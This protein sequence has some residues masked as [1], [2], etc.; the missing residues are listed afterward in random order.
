M[1]ICLDYTHGHASTHK[2]IIRIIRLIF[3]FCEDKKR[4]KNNT[5]TH[6]WQYDIHHATHMI[7]TPDCVYTWASSTHLYTA[8]MIFH[9][10]R[11]HGTSWQSIYK[12]ALWFGYATSFL[13]LFFLPSR[14]H[15]HN[16]CVQVMVL[17][18]INKTYMTHVCLCLG[19]CV[20]MCVSVHVWSVCVF[21]VWVW[22]SSLWPR[23]RKFTTNAL[24]VVTI[25]A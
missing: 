19:V 21:F 24:R 22:S 23:H 4:K 3:I 6:P 5:H 12:T 2:Y 16:N 20:C 15:E 9:Y 1:V 11:C 8:H 25:S 14:R 18:S 17:G 7:H 13:M 10:I